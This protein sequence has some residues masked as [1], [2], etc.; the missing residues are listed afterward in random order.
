[1]TRQHGVEFKK[2]EGAGYNELVGKLRGVRDAGI[3]RLRGNKD[4]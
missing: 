4:A 2:T 1:M 3:R